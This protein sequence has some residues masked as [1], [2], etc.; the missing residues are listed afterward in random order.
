MKKTVHLYIFV[1]LSSI[2]SLLRIFNVFFSK[3]DETVM[4]Q[5]FQ[6]LEGIDEAMFTF[7]RESISFQTNLINRAF[8]VVLLLTLVAVVVLLFLGKNK[9]ASCT[10][11]GYLIG[12]LLL[13]T[14]S[15]VGS[16]GLTQIYTDLT[17]RQ[18][19]EIQTLAFYVVNIVLF[20]IYFGV[21]IFFHLRKPK[22]ELSETNHSTDI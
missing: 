13:H 11:L 20:L 3:Y 16:K 21:T 9:Q 19:V 10:Y 5:L 22:Q 7:M 4:R 1:I 15:F 6:N 14:Y 12:T 18:I 8:A 2:A 17:T